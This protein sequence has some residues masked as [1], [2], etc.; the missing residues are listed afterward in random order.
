MNKPYNRIDR[1]A[2]E[3]AHNSTKYLHDELSEKWGIVTCTK[4]DLSDDLHS[5]KIWIS[6]YPQL[7]NGKKVEEVIAPYKHGLIQYLKQRVP[8][9]YVP[10]FS[11]AVDISGEDADRIEKLMEQI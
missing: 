9:K 2:E 8:M 7:P 10:R 6:F 4:V 3:L 5:A 11:F 1:I